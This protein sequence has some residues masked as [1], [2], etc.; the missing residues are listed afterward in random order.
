MV[1]PSPRTRRAPPGRWLFPLAAAFAA[2]LPP[3]WLADARY[4]VSWH[5]HELLFGYGLAVVGGFLITR[6]NAASG[7]VLFAAWAAGRV[8]ALLPAG[9]V[10]GVVAGLAFDALLLGSALPPLVRGAKRP[11]NY[12]VPLVVAGLFAVDLCWWLGTTWLGEPLARRSLL[13][14][15]DLF[16]L[17]LLIVGGRVLPA[18]VGGHL[19][20]RGIPRRDRIRRGFELPLAALAGTAFILEL[21]GWPVP[22]GGFSAV[23]ALVG[24]VRAAS[25]QLE[26]TMRQPALGGLTL[27]YLWLVFGMLVNG[28]SQAMTL[29]PAAEGL[30]GITIGALGTFT[31]VMMART[32][33][34][35]ARRPI[36]G[37]ADVGLAAGLVSLAA[38]LRL[39]A[40]F[41]AAEE[42]LLWAAALAWSAA[43]TIVLL[44]LLRLARPR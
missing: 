24:L 27:G 10:P 29:L 22:A 38:T 31:L 1:S 41:A 32:A 8:A 25:W 2:L 20:R 15:V 7:W 37:F 5:G 42:S 14:T 16:A 44:R 39:A 6:S 12:V 9:G 23:A 11:E 19:E 40:P 30:H 43:F 17:L 28:L 35:R 36:E 21:S 18:A 4:A 34:L 13:A 33:T 3:L 26:H